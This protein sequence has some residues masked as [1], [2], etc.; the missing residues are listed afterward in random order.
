M[1][2]YSLDPGL[3]SLFCSLVRICQ[4]IPKNKNE[5][6][7][8]TRL[9]CVHVWS[10]YRE[11]ASQHETGNGLIAAIKECPCAP[12]KCD[13]SSNSICCALYMAKHKL[14]SQ[15]F[16]PMPSPSW[17]LLLVYGRL[18]YCIQRGSYRVSTV[19]HFGAHFSLDWRALFRV[20]A[21][22]RGN[23]MGGRREEENS[24]SSGTSSSG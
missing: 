5:V 21:V 3:S 17:T 14:P 12:L 7:L 16:R 8:G 9:V 4:R 20:Q 22:V 1:C 18:D 23:W 10:A 13:C 15:L 6:G 2:V 19:V 11:G 24:S